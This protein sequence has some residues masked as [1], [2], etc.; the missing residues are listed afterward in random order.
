MKQN[1]N[2]IKEP[3]SGSFSGSFVGDGSRLTGIATGSNFNSSSLLLTSSF[4]TYTASVK[5]D[6]ASFDSRI[7]LIPTIS[8]NFSNTD[9]IQ[10]ENRN[11][12][13]SG[14]N[15]NLNTLGNWNFNFNSNKNFSVNNAFQVY[16]ES[17]SGGKTSNFYL[18]EDFLQFY[19]Y[20]N[21][22]GG[23]TTVD[24]FA[25]EALGPEV[26]MSGRIG[27]V[28]KSEFV[29]R[30]GP[31]GKIIARPYLGVFEIEN[32]TNLTTQNRLIGQD[33]TTN[34]LG[35]INI[36]GS[37]LFLSGGLLT[38]NLDVNLQS[39]NQWS[40]SINL[41]TSSINQFTQSINTWSS[42]LD[43]G[44]YVNSSSFNQYTSSVKLDS[45]SFDSRINLKN[46]QT[47]FVAYSQSI[48]TYTASVIRDSASFDS[49]I[50]NIQPTGFV[51]TSSFG[52]Y[53]SSINTWSSSINN[54][55]ASNRLDSASFD[56]RI[57][58][59]NDQTVFVAYTSSINAYTASNK[60]DSASFS[61]RI[62]QD[63]ISQSYY[64]LTSS[65]NN[66]SQSINS[67]TSSVTRD[68]ASFDSRINLKTDQTVFVAYSQSINTYTASVTR[69]SAS[70]NSLLQFVSKSYVAFTQSINQW[71]SSNYV[72]TSSLSLLGLI[73]ASASNT[74]ITFTKGDGSTFNVV[75][76]QSGSVASSSYALF[77]ES[78]TTAS[79]AIKAKTLEGFEVFTQSI[80]NFSS[81]INQY[82]ASNKLD[83]A[84]FDSR[85]NS[86]RTDIFVTTSSFGNYTSSIN[87]FT[88]SVTRDSASL[89]SL[90][91]FVSKSYTEFTQSYYQ[92]SASFDSRI[93]ALSGGGIS[94]GTFNPFTQSI[95]NWSSSINLYTASVTRDSAS[96]DSRINLKTDISEFRPYSQSVNLFTASVTRD[97]ASFDSRINL[98]TDQTVFVA[99]TASI[100]NWSQS[101][102]LYTASDILNSASF[103]SRINLKTDQTVFVAYTSSINAYTA[104]NILNSASFDS[105]INLKTDQTVF[106]AYS[107]SINTYTASVKLDSASFDSRI[108]LKTDQTV[109]VAFTQS[110]HTF[111]ASINSFTSSTV[112]N[113][114]SFDSR[115]RFISASYVAFTQSYYVDSASFAQRINNNDVSGY[116]KTSSFHPYSASINTWSQSIN[117][118]TAS[119]TLNSASFDSR[120]NLKTD[121]TVFVAFSQS[122][123]T[124]TASVTRDSASFNSRINN[125]TPIPTSSFLTNNAD[126]FSV[127]GGTVQRTLT[128]SGS[129]ITLQG[130]GS[131]TV[132]FPT[133]SDT[134]VGY[135]HFGTYTAS[136]TRDSASFDI[137]INS[138][139]G[140]GGG[141]L[142]WTSVTGTSQT[143]VVDNGYIANN[144]SLVTLTLPTT[145]AVGKIVSVV[146]LGAGGWRIAQNASEIIHFGDTPT[147]TGTGGYIES[148]NRY[149]CVELICIVAD[150]EWSVRHSTGNITINIS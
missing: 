93:T 113:S 115:I 105:R 36:T 142:T 106:V 101:I 99:Y 62:T 32:L 45:A 37:G 44:K 92:T 132:T 33:S 112:L 95:H 143:M 1:L 72:Q 109:F 29:V 55:T 91:Q 17:T 110:I 27:G 87:S 67:F 3:F 139:S 24:L 104:S 59:K 122:I 10:V 131:S 90:L 22:T 56:S 137:R 47:V 70:F 28:Q 31:T 136:V 89:N 25:S 108:N 71:S 80:H 97:S 111:T 60:L 58:L 64:V 42:S 4:N 40:S 118:Y 61:N 138:V 51:T 65:F 148:T 119:N 83:S 5:L 68:S 133:G 146:G 30:G 54:Y 135:A 66:Y 73:T 63:V 84:S 43:L 16:L 14:Y 57:N 18:L 75:V 12:T 141:G 69:D 49:R 34:R 53:T 96:F 126:G 20:D 74:T 123:H 48:N 94:A 6:S 19:T 107:Q 149:D 11:Y 26:F 7:K 38:V 98:K 52:N 124:F 130:S 125:I 85:I 120:I 78:A 46:D 8:Y 88:A 134:L 144:A 2:Q 86:I 35:Y 79:Y 81:S 117:T 145:A 50:N 39:L 41:Y 127:F 147:L 140:S 82:T 129:N 114:A 150:T 100:N 76:S 121:Q 15:Y 77:A 103:S 9:L 102:N 23:A 21:A 116:T 128:V 13:G